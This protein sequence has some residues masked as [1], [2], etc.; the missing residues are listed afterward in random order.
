MAKTAAKKPATKTEILNA[1]AEKTELTKKQV[2][3]VFDALSEEIA[4]AVGKK[5]PGSFTIPGLCKIVLKHNE[6][7]PKRKGR[8]PATG[9]EMWFAPKP[10]S[11]SIKIRPLKALKD[12]AP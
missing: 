7:K 11:N 3:A 6:A 12:M 8:N 9:E 2:A 10:A 4:S 5:G 1:I